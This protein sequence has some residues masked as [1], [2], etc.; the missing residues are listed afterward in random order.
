MIPYW[1]IDIHRDISL[2]SITVLT[3]K[4][5]ICFYKPFLICFMS[6]VVRPQ[7]NIE[8]VEMNDDDKNNK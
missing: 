2:M 5:M 6:K 8:E 7:D 1:T 3:L 4:S